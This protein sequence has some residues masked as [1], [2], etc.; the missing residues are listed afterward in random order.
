MDDDD[1]ILFWHKETSCKSSD[2]D[3]FADLTNTMFTFWCFQFICYMF[4]KSGGGTEF[5]TSS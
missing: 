4:C 1:D 5:S 3:H 2:V